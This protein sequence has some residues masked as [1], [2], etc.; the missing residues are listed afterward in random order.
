MEYIYT[1]YST[2]FKKTLYYLHLFKED[3]AYFCNINDLKYY[4]FVF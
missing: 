2:V 1:Y 3:M 4:Y